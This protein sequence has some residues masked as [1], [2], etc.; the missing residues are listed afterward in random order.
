MTMIPKDFRGRAARLVDIDLPRVGHMLGVGEDEVHAVLDVEARGSGFDAKGRPTMLFEPH[1]FW[2]EMGGSGAKRSRAAALGLAYEKWG[3]KPYPSDSYPRLLLA[4]QIDETAA[5][6]SASWGLGQLLGSNHVAAGYATPQAMVA[7]FCDSEAAQLEGMAGFIR[8]GG[9]DRHLRAHAWAA[10]AR[11]YNGPG[12]AKNQYDVRLA[13]AYARWRGISDT[14]WSPRDA[15]VETVQNDPVA[16]HV[17]SPPVAA[18]P[19]GAGGSSGG[20]GASGA[21]DA[22]ATQE[23]AMGAPPPVQSPPAVAASAT[24]TDAPSPGLWSR[25]LAALAKRIA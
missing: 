21:G 14:P 19:E 9:L 4:M 25:F 5:L 6:R 16:P 23:K 24:V 20:E 11:L 2:R 18:A 7:A 13:R 17:V 8:K 3:A 12:Y 15:A 1:L 22:P 10:F